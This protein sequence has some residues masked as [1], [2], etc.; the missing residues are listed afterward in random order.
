[1]K[2]LLPL[3]ILTLFLISVSSGAVIQ[4]SVKH[5]LISSSDT[6]YEGVITEGTK[7]QGRGIFVVTIDDSLRKGIRYEG[8]FLGTKFHGQGTM[9]FPDGYKYVGEFKGGN[10][11]GQGTFTFADGRKYVGEWK[12]GKQNGQG[13]HTWPN[14]DKYVGDWKDDKPNGQGTYTWPNGDK[15]VGEFKDGSHNGQGTGTFAVGSKYVGDWKDDK[16]NGQGTYTLPDGRQYVGEK[17]DK[18]EEYDY[19]KEMEKIDN[20][21]YLAE[22]GVFDSEDEE[23]ESLFQPETDEKVWADFMTNN[24]N[25]DK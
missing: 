13:T 18:E 8:E 4:D 16:P 19:D 11:D 10:Y 24:I 1:M 25:F 22:A 15:Y 17:D 9:T 3:L 14:G 5:T 7:E 2:R 6:P 23:Y 20:L 12:D 21:N